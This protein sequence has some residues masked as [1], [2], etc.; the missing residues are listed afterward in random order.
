MLL[1][2]KN[3]RLCSTSQILHTH[4]VCFHAL[5]NKPHDCIFLSSFKSRKLYSSFSFVP[6]SWYAASSVL[7][8]SYFPPQLFVF[9]LLS[10]RLH[11]HLLG[12]EEENA[13]KCVDSAPE[14]TVVKE[15]IL[16]K[17]DLSKGI[18]SRRLHRNCF[19]CVSRLEAML[20]LDLTLK[21]LCR[22]SFVWGHCSCS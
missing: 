16:E 8:C 3:L 18:S 1:K 13:S 7:T 21:S 11:A 10:F 9:L 4:N 6:F 12:V 15:R 14:K 17:I 2:K 19:V 22:S 5:M 20:W